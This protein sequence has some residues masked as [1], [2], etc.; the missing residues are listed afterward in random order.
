M[1][2]LVVG[3]LIGG[4]RAF[5]GGGGRALLPAARPEKWLPAARRFGGSARMQRQAASV[6]SFD[7]LPAA[8]RLAVKEVASLDQGYLRYSFDNNMDAVV[9]VVEKDAPCWDAVP[10]GP[11]VAKRLERREAAAA[12]A[13]AGVSPATELPNDI[14]TRFVV[15]RVDSARSQHDL[16]SDCG[17]TVE[18]A[19]AGLGP[20]RRV[21]VVAP[22]IA[23]EALRARVRDGVLAAATAA[24]EPKP[25]KETR[26]TSI[27][28]TLVGL[29]AR[30]AREKATEDAAAVARYL[31]ALPPNV[32]TPG[33]F[34][35]ALKTLA[36]D[37]GFEYEEMDVDDL[38]EARCGA[39][40]SVVRGSPKRD[41]ALVRLSK[42]P[43]SP[44]GA[45]LCFV[46]KGVT[47]DTGGV[48]V[49]GASGM[50]NMKGDMAGASAAVGAAVALGRLGVGSGDGESFLSETPLEVFIACAD[51]L[52]SAESYFPDEVV[53]A[54]DGTTI[55]IVHTDA[56]GRMLLADAL[57]MASRKVVPFRG[58][59]DAKPALLVD[60]ATLIGSAIG[61]LSKGYGAAFSNDPVLERTNAAIVAAGSAAG[62]R[63]WPM[64]PV[65]ASFKKALDSDVADISQC[66]EAGTA[67]HLYAAAFLQ[68][69]VEE[70]CPW[71]HLDLAAASSDKGLAHVRSGGPTGYGVRAAVALVLDHWEEVAWAPS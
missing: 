31:A 56:E 37:E 47:F 38:E 39:F 18:A 55:E 15:L 24:Y 60:M 69:F 11:V 3:A 66:L 67:D 58:E 32:L 68:H 41:A 25:K 26:P 50:K 43:S 34:R 51:N 23:D 71:I 10:Y 12:L 5:M 36:E 28:L 62:E 7:L 57:A 52:I 1:R 46:G 17:E 53:A 65:D 40:L 21:S 33:A 22:R 48:N 4:G 64:P 63:L 19:C 59:D 70:G 61:A 14:G 9:L 2:G 13:E 20:H 35:D 16:L 8:P 44:G 42:R 6:A 49:K 54:C 29:D 30:T 27:D 45:P